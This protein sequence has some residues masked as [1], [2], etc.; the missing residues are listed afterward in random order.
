MHVYNHPHNVQKHTN[1]VL[2][3]IRNDIPYYVNAK[4]ALIYKIYE[5]SHVDSQIK[6]RSQIITNYLCLLCF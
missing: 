2:K 3:F 4:N 5:L 6:D 1:I